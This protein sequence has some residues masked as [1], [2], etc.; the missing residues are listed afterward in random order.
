MEEKRMGLGLAR[1]T[2][3]LMDFSRLDSNS[4][5]A[6]IA[7]MAEELRQTILRTDELERAGYVD[8][9]CMES[10]VV[11]GVWPDAEEPT[12]F[13]VYLLGTW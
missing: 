13:G 11:F 2:S 10:D 7:D 6:A 12:G 4:F 3:G 1:P 8:R 5:F 9:L